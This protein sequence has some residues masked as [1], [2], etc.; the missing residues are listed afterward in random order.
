M[1]KSLVRRSRETPE[2][3]MASTAD[4]AFLLILFFMVTTVIRVAT[5]LEVDRPLAESTERIK[6][7]HNLVHLWIDVSQHIQIDD[8]SV[9]L[10]YV[11]DRMIEKR[12]KNPDLVTILEVDRE[13]NYGFVDQVMERLKEAGAFRIT[14]ATDLIERS[15]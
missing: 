14:F 2:I 15:E 7:R 13:V 4:I 12:S 10:D 9:P 1:H 3:P 6:I 11:T 5:G 8:F